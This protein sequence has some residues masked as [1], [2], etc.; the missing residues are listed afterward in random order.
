MAQM[1]ANENN[2][3][4]PISPQSQPETGSENEIKS[5][6]SHPET[7]NGNEDPMAIISAQPSLYKLFE[8][9][10]DCESD[11]ITDDEEYDRTLFSTE[12]DEYDSEGN[13]T[14]GRLR[15]TCDDDGTNITK[16][17]FVEDGRPV[18]EEE[19]PLAI[20]SC[21]GIQLKCK[22][23]GIM[24]VSYYG[25][26]QPKVSNY[27]REL[28]KILKRNYFEM[29]HRYTVLFA[30]LN[31]VL[32]PMELIV[33]QYV[34]DYHKDVI[35]GKITLEQLI[36]ELILNEAND[37]LCLV[38]RYFDVSVSETRP[39]ALS[40]I[41]LGV[42]GEAFPD[43]YQFGRQNFVKLQGGLGKWNK[44]LRTDRMGTCWIRP[45]PALEDLEN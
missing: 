41:E 12:D 28:A 39:P 37:I 42:N 10:F 8:H 15:F 6:E 25:G 31:R 13:Y 22:Q 5:T 14:P 9:V 2:T 24:K 17:C 16:I 7:E 27:K 44:Y 35:S 1:D 36:V 3:Q 45:I 26:L 32:N 33:L 19:L 30:I 18:L 29:M 21:G 38:P 34:N 20:T 43:R 40:R 4:A 23:N 11:F